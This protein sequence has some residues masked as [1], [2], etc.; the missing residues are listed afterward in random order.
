MKEVPVDAIYSSPL[1]R[2][3]ETA[4]FIAKGRG[5]RVRNLE[6]AGEIHYGDWQGRSLKSLTKTKAWTELN[7]KRADFRFPNGE[8][9]REAQARGIRAVES[10]LKDHN[11]KVV[12]LVSHADLIRLIIA[13]YIGLSLELYNRFTIN[14]AT[15]SALSLGWHIPS[16]VALNHPGNL[17]WIRDYMRRRTSSANARPSRKR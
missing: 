12:A 16:L 11:R 14:P 7:R 6:D 17:D 4:Q 10:L 1:E 2:C 13:G 8:T 9:P 5:L 3:R 15:V